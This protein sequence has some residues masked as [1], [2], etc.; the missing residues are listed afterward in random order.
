MPIAK[1]FARGGLLDRHTTALVVWDGADIRRQAFN[2][3]AWE[4]F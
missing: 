4:R 3:K 2:Y 1:P